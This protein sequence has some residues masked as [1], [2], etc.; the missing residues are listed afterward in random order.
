MSAMVRTVSVLA[1]PGTPSS[2]TWPLH[3][4]ADEDALEHVA[5]ADDD[6]AGLLVEHLDEAALLLDAL[7]Q[8]PDVRIHG[9]RFS[10]CP[11]KAGSLGGGG[12]PLNNAVGLAFR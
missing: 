3:K 12:S 11:W 7:G 5:L 6:L 4:Q 9:V 10:T 1:R 8:R 2:S